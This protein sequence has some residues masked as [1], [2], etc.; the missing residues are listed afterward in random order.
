MITYFI[1]TKWNDIGF[2]RWQNDEVQ[3]LSVK[4]ISEYVVIEIEGDPLPRFEVRDRRTGTTLSAHGS[5]GEADKAANAAN[6]ANDL[7]H[8]IPDADSDSGTRM[9]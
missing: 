8:N 2:D 6:A 9:S 5:K 7:K 4:M 1:I 3:S